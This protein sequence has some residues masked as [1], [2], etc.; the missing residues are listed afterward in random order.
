MNL[1]RKVDFFDDFDGFG[2]ISI[3]SEW[4]WK[5]FNEFG[6]ISIDLDGF[7]SKW[8]VESAP[9]QAQLPPPGIPGPHTFIRQSAGDILVLH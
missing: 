8:G 4:I 6:R 9:R 7:Q 5:D 2:S 3:D 1:K